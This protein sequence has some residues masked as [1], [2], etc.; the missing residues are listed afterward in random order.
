M[1]KRILL[2]VFALVV[3]A[4]IAFAFVPGQ[5]RIFD[6]AASKLTAKVNVAPLV[7]D[8]LRVAICGSSA[9]LASADRAKACVA[10][11][12][13]GKFYV[14]DAGSESTERLVLWESRSRRSVPSC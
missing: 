2:L 7:D 6:R 4:A 5:Q 11:F 10:V 8:A 13:G 3:A 9:P 1:L 14:V 12:A